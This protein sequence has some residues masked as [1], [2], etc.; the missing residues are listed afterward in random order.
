V[1]VL[2]IDVH[3]REHREGHV[4]RRRAERLDLRLVARLLVAELVAREAEDRE[5]PLGVLLVEALQALVLRGVTTFDA[6]FTTSTTW[7]S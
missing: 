3:L 4:V 5:P 7:P 6:V 2:A 1:G